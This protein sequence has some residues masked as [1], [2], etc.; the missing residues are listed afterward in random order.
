MSRLK[1]LSGAFAGST[2]ATLLMLL[3]TP[4]VHRCGT[5]SDGAGCGMEKG[6]LEIGVYGLA[7]L[8]GLLVLL[9][10]QRPRAA[11]YAAFGLLIVVAVPVAIHL[12]FLF[13]ERI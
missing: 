6:L 8:V 13:T 1:S 10:C 11:K 3:L 12:M 7:I 2:F 4:Q 5:G 9:F